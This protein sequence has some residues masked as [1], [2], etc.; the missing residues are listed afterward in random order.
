[1]RV[2]EHT[3]RIRHI[4]KILYHWRMIPGSIAQNGDSKGKVEPLQCAAVNLHMARLKL[5]GKAVPHPVHAHR[6]LIIPTKVAPPYSMTV[7]I[8]KTA[9]HVNLNRCLDS[10][11]GARME[12]EVLLFGN[13]EAFQ[14]R[15]GV[16]VMHL[17]SPTSQVDEKMMA[18]NLLNRVLTEARGDYVLFMEYPMVLSPDWDERLALFCSRPNCG[19]VSPLVLNADGTVAEA[20]LLLHPRIGFE[21]AMK[22]WEPKGDGQAGSLSCARE[23]SAV[24]A[25]CVCF[26]KSLVQ[27]IGGFDSIYW[28]A[29][30][31]VADASLKSMILGMSNLYVP[32]VIATHCEPTHRVNTSNENLDRELFMD[33]WSRFLNEGDRYHNPNFSPDNGGYHFL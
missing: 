7:V 32:T 27:Q 8:A 15:P 9:A 3:D 12:T 25:S 13:D 4:P 23:V 10:L 1:L 20:G 14:F 21:P 17:S 16:R 24:S 28:C 26:R 33:R 31:Q 30:F 29:T 2:G 18:T 5:E 22:G 6:A 11:T 19:L